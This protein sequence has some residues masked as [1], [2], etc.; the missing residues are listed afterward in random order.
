MARLRPQPRGSTESYPT[1]RFDAK[2]LTIPS[3]KPVAWVISGERGFTG[4]RPAFGIRRWEPTS[5]PKRISRGP[6]ACY[7][8]VLWLNSRKRAQ[9]CRYVKAHQSPVRREEHRCRQAHHAG[10]EYDET[11]GPP[12][13]C[14]ARI[15]PEI[16]TITTLQR[17][18]NEISGPIKLHERQL[19]HP[20]DGSGHGIAARRTYV[21]RK[22]GAERDRMSF[23]QA[24]Q[25]RCQT[26]FGE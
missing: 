24:R 19:D 13:D 8:A 12:V 25:C 9:G 10:D 4:G 5:M 26:T 11:S 6:V 15:T 2:F 22:Q 21:A 23:N 14:A 17:K 18:R 7:A 3:M 20:R 1:A 16:R